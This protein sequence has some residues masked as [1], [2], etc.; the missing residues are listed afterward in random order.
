MMRRPGVKAIIGTVIV[1]L[2]LAVT[3]TLVVTR[4]DRL[5]VAGIYTGQNG[6]EIH[7]SEDGTLKVIGLQTIGAM[8]R[9]PLRYWVSGR[10]I[11]LGNLNSKSPSKGPVVFKVE[12]DNNLVGWDTIWFKN[13]IPLNRPSSLV[14]TYTSIAGDGQTL[15]LDKNGAA[16]VTQPLP[17]GETVGDGTWVAAN[18]T[19]TVTYAGNGKGN[20]R[21]STYAVN[22]T[23]LLGGGK[24]LTRTSFSAI[25]PATL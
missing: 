21:K 16:Y 20:P 15:A 3:I 8:T 6:R 23:S 17:T 12:P 13:V 25:V 24:E 10:D 14:G 11:L 5:D 4:Q 1:L 18:N 9:V 22:G 2:A 19:I 7:L